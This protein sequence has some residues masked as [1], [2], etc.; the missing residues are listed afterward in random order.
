MNDK[1]TSV[2]RAQVNNRFCSLLFDS[3]ANLS[4]IDAAYANTVGTTIRELDQSDPRYIIAANSKVARILGKTVITLKMAGFRLTGTFFILENLSSKIIVGVDLMT[5]FRVVCDFDKGEITFNGGLHRVPLIRRNEFV[6]IAR[7][8]KPVNIG[9]GRTATVPVTGRGSRRLSGEVKIYPLVNPLRSISVEECDRAGCVCLTNTS[10]RRLA[11]RKFMPIACIAKRVISEQAEINSD[12]LNPVLNIQTNTYADET[13]VHTDKCTQFTQTETN[14]ADIVLSDDSDDEPSEHTDFFTSTRVVPNRTCDDMHIKFGDCNI[15]E[16]MLLKFKDLVTKYN[17]VFA[18]SNEEL[19]EGVDMEELGLK[20]VEIHLKDPN[21]PPVRSHIFKHTLAER[22]EVG[23]QM[24]EM[25]DIGFYSRET[26]PYACG[27]LVVS[28]CGSSAKRVCWDLRK[29][30]DEIKDFDFP[31]PTM[32]EIVR[33]VGGGV[34]II[35]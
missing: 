29:L 18:C 8:L 30:N 27:L 33:Q 2:V 14:K 17:D 32:E 26:S 13:S 28:K 20:P 35:F 9:A 4:C 24:Q 21:G 16:H 12:I 34:P 15:P 23:K 7:V 11:L 5:T 19:R 10:R 3:G 25:C 22:A 6:G 1:L 31:T